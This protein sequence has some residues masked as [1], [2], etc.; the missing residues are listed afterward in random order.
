MGFLIEMV[1]AAS[2]D[3]MGWRM[4]G[5]GVVGRVG[6]VGGVN[7]MVGNAAVNCVEQ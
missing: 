2:S 1:G 3:W 6:R 4:Q 7:V 5:G